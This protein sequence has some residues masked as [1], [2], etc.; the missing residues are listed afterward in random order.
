MRS[1]EAWGY[2]WKNGPVSLQAPEF[3][4]AMEFRE[5]FIS[6]PV[7]QHGLSLRLLSKLLAKAQARS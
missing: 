2:A 7:L 4:R 3:F 6:M 5:D 1:L